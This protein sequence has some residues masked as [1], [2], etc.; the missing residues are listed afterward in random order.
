VIGIDYYRDKVLTFDI[1][2]RELIVAR[3]SAPA[4]QK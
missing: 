4:M 2:H 3:V 1:V